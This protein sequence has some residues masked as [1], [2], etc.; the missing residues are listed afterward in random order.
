MWLTNI[1]RWTSG[2]LDAMV[3]YMNIEDPKWLIERLGEI[4]DD[5]RGRAI[6][7]ELASNRRR[8]SPKEME[9][10]EEV[11][12]DLRKARKYLQRLKLA[13]KTSNSDCSIG[14]D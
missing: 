9:R 2:S 5:T 6:L 4:T 14:W 7:V 10:I 13:I 1:K 3:R 11:L 12:N 8:L